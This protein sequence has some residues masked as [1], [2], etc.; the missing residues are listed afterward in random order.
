MSG[1]E[2]TDKLKAAGLCPHGNFVASCQSCQQE[3]DSKLAR[4]VEAYINECLRAEV[5]PERK[6]ELNKEL[7]SVMDF[8]ESAGIDTYIAGG[9][10]LDLLDGEW[11]RDHQDLDV[12]IMGSNRQK[13][14]EAATNAGF[15]ITDPDEKILSLS[16]ISSSKTENAFVSRTDDQ[17]ITCCE[18][19]FLNETPTGDI[20]L[21]DSVAIPMASYEKALSV[22]VNGRE[23]RLQPPEIILF[24]KLKDGRRK[25]FQDAKKVWNMLSETQQTALEKYLK[26]ADARFV[27]DS[28]E[29]RDVSALFSRAEQVDA[30]K[31]YQFFSQEVSAIKLELEEKLIQHCAE[32]FQV[33]QSVQERSDFFEALRQKYQGF[34]PE[35]RSFINKMTD[36][37]YG[38]PPIS[39]EQFSSWAKQAAN[40]DSRLKDMSLHKYKED[41]LWRTKLEDES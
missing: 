20:E 4:E 35:N 13:F 19:M 7:A 10:G 16:D 11:S 34:M 33:R 41:K 36:V 5:S 9:S 2:S 25:D 24:H 31:R 30:A 32:I 8:F 27:I 26:Q 38:Q 18:V 1:E 23:V 39:R 37:L 21:V 12:A 40:T 15:T 17:G 29:I 14:F 22:N 3:S 28:D 6:A